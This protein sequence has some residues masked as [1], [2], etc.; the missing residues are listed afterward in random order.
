VDKNASFLTFKRADD[1]WV[2]IH[3]VLGYVSTV[4]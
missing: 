3:C 4:F 2:C 1:T